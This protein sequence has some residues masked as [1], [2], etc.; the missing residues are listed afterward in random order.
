MV[1]Y[2]YHI[3]SRIDWGY[4]NGIWKGIYRKGFKEG[5]LIIDDILSNVY[6]TLEKIKYII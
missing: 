5:W 6:V 4:R 2:R 1:D 3:L